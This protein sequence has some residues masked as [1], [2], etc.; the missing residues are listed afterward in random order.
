MK[1][2]GDNTPL[3][4][5]CERNSTLTVV[6][7][8]LDHGA[9]LTATNSNGETA[10]DVAMKNDKTTIVAHLSRLGAKSAVTASTD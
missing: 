6:K 9:S 8:L 5:A 10:L 3:H 1:D 4:K 2:Q 7:L